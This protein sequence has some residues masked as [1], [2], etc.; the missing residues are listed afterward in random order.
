[1]TATDDQRIAYYTS[2]LLGLQ[3]VEARRPTGRRFGSEADARWASFRGELATADR[4][5]LLVRDADTEWPGAF[6][7]RTVF[8]LRAL[9][10]DEPFGAEWTPL[11]PVHAEEL[12]RSVTAQSA[13]AGVG[14]VLGAV[15]SQWDLSLSPFDVGGTV[16]ASERLLVTGPSAIAS[17]VAAFAEGTGLDWA[18]QVVCLA[19]PPGHRQLAA[20]AGA[21]LRS[22]KPT[23]ILSVDQVKD[24][25]AEL[26]AGRRLVA[27]DDADRADAARARELCEEPSN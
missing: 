1:M 3:H 26:L 12:W 2:V 13:P 5:D 19:S 21:A 10:E 16:D 18:D 25:S 8:A 27:S 23:T 6:G 17:L 20:M 9:R 24:A 22:S 4:I 11:E 14:D 15:A 7:P